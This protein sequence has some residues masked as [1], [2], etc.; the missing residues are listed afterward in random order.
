MCIKNSLCKL[1]AST[2]IKHQKGI[3]IMDESCVEND[4][5]LGWIFFGKILRNKS[6]W[7]GH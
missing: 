3:L 2:S 4:N 7:N 6:Y 5:E 1:Y